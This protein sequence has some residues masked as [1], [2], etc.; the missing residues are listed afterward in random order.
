M[1]NEV[2]NGVQTLSLWIGLATAIGTIIGWLISAGAKSKSTRPRTRPQGAW[3]RVQAISAMTKI[4]D[5]CYL[6]TMASAAARAAVEAEAFAAVERPVKLPAFMA[7][8]YFLIGGLAFWPTFDLKTLGVGILGVLV[9]LV[10]AAVHLAR[11]E[12]DQLSIRAL[13]DNENE[14]ILRDPV[15]ALRRHREEGLPGNR[16]DVRILLRALRFRIRKIS[17]QRE[18]LNQQAAALDIREKQL[19]SKEGGLARREEALKCAGQRLDW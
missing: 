11:N 8:I 5:D 19:E 3:E 12:G 6:S 2:V 18:E 9:F 15:Q 1:W 4:N 17:A 16:N 14:E 13:V 7:L 10:L